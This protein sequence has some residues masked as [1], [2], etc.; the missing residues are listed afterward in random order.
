MKKFSACTIFLALT[1][2]FHFGTMKIVHADQFL[3]EVHCE[4]TEIE[5]VAR[6]IQGNIYLALKADKTVKKST[7]SVRIRKQPAQT[8]TLSETQLLTDTGYSFN[9]S[10]LSVSIGGNIIGHACFSEAHLLFNIQVT[11]KDESTQSN[12]VT[13]PVNVPGAYATSGKIVIP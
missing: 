4:P 6:V 1:V 9:P 12:E 8:F 13:I 11:R 7:I 2:T 10:D 3:Y 5:D